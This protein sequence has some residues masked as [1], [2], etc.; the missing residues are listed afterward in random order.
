LSSPGRAI[1]LSWSIPKNIHETLGSHEVKQKGGG[2]NSLNLPLP[3]YIIEGFLTLSREWK[4]CAPRDS[5]LGRK[6]SIQG[7]QRNRLRLPQIELGIKEGEHN[8]NLS[9]GTVRLYEGG[10]GA[11]R[12]ASQDRGSN[13]RTGHGKPFAILALAWLRGCGRQTQARSLVVKVREH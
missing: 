3:L 4:V 13:R 2:G 7:S 5:Y 6:V 10:Q 9:E 8:I 11:R 12:R 1:T